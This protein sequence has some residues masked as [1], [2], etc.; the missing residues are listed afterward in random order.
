MIRASEQQRQPA[1]KQATGGGTA[2]GGGPA[3]P[4][5]SQ[6]GP[7]QPAVEVP[8]FLRNGYRH[9]CP[10][11]TAGTGKKFKLFPDHDHG[12]TGDNH[13]FASRGPRQRSNQ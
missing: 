7:G 4:S 3:V 5:V 6:N 1:V 13:S 12:I 9:R 10:A 8:R 11:A 2:T